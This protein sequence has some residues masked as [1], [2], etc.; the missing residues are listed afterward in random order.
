M[1]LRKTCSC[2]AHIQNGPHRLSPP[3]ESLENIIDFS[4]FI[5]LTAD[6]RSQ[7]HDRFYAVI[8]HFS[9]PNTK[10]G[11][12]RPL[13]VWYMFEYARSE[14]SQDIILR[15]FFE[16]LNLGLTSDDDDIDFDDQLGIGLTTFADFLIDNFFLLRLI[17]YL[18]VFIISCLL[19]PCI[20]KAS[21]HST[22]QPSPAHLSIIQ[23]DEFTAT[24]DRLSALGVF[25]LSVT[26]I[27]A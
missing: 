2:I 18:P 9:A 12:S 10:E 22:A 17:S 26:G 25:V 4:S 5:P 20:S 3:L 21:G 8:N 19:A 1:Q 11:Y 23:Q 27:V 16:F 15:V 6:Q 14:L 13:L 7:A 24:P